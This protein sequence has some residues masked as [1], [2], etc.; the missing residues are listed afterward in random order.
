MARFWLMKL[1]YPSLLYNERALLFQSLAIFQLFS[2]M[3]WKPV[4]MVNVR[5]ITYVVGVLVV[6]H[7]LGGFR[8]G[9]HA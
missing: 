6:R 3:D 2:P 9:S 8:R 4:S 7:D 1:L 5:V